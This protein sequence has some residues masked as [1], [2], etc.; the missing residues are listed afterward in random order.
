M[1]LR[2]LKL[3]PTRYCILSNQHQFTGLHQFAG[4]Y[5]QHINAVLQ[6]LAFKRH[7]VGFPAS[8]QA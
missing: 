1:L 5:A 3:I 8:A 4:G 2:L 6:P 7:L